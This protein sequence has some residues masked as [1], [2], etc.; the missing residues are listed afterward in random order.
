MKLREAIH[1]E[2]VDLYNKKNS[3][4]EQRFNNE[5]KDINES[6]VNIDK[7]GTFILRESFNGEDNLNEGLF[8]FFGN[9]LGGLGGNVSEQL[10]EWAIGKVMDWFVKPL[11][12]KLGADEGLYSSL[13]TYVQVTFADIP[14]MEIMSTITN[15][16]K[17]T[18]ILV[19]G[20][21][22]F[23]LTSML[24]KLKLDSVFIDT[25]RQELDKSFIENSAFINKI[26]MKVSDVVCGA[27]DG[28]KNNI[29]NSPLAGA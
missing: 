25:I 29:A 13:R 22:E 7:L 20:F 9:L 16:A 15:C 4:I 10:K 14:L 11:V 2:L 17:M 18:K 24:S 5:F 19:L 21:F 26:S 3:T 27:A 1:S 8:D 12:T 6:N 28:L 23:V